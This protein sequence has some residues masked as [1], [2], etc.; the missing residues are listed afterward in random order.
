VRLRHMGSIWLQP[1]RV[2]Q[3][4]FNFKLSRSAPEL[5]TMVLHKEIQGDKFCLD[6]R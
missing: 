3:L 5:D 2:D 6:I 1:K 4:G